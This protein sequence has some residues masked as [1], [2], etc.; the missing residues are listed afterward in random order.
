MNKKY[1]IKGAFI[2]GLF[3]LVSALVQQHIEPIRGLINKDAGKVS[4]VLIVTAAVIVA[5]V[6]ATPMIPVASNVWGWITG[7]LLS[8]IGWM[9]GSMTAFMIARKFGV[10]II[11]KFVSTQSI[12]KI[13]SKIQAKN[14][15]W[16]LVFL[17]TIMPVDILSYAAGLFSSISYKQFFLAT[18]LGLVPFAF[19]FAYLGSIPT[20]YQIISF[21]GGGIVLGIV[22][23]YYVLREQKTPASGNNLP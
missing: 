21:T 5:P 8:F 4:Y 17:R 14:I 15:F 2:L 13:Q 7:G 10:Q 1:L 9:A 3:I 19:L 6:S 12:E 23:Y 16:S 11:G 22:I 18:A 20:L